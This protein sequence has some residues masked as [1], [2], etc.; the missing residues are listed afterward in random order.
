M[1]KPHL[2]SH[3][4][5]AITRFRSART[6]RSYEFTLDPVWFI[7]REQKIAL[8]WDADLTSAHEK[9]HGDRRA[10]ANEA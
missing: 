10:P 1:L 9:F 2:A 3:D 4:G 5:I 6:A 7:I 8:A